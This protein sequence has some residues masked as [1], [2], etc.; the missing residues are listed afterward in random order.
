MEVFQVLCEGFLVADPVDDVGFAGVAVAYVGDTPFG[1]GI[2][3]EL[4]LAVGDQ[5]ASQGFFWM[6]IKKKRMNWRCLNICLLRT[7]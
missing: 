5:S 7:R 1:E 2:K 6:N 4:V 3:R